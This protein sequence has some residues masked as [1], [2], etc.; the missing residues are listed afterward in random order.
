MARVC[1]VPPRTQRG[2]ALLLVM[3]LIALLAALVGGFAMAARIEHLQ[4]QVLA[5]GLVA[6][7]AARAGVE[8]A[9]VRLADP[10]PRRRWQPDGRDYRWRFGSAQVL[11]RV[12]DEGGKID[13][14]SAQPPL[15]SGLF[16]ALG[17]ERQQAERLAGA[18]V[19]WRDP[20]IL[21]QPSGGGED[22]DYEAAGLPYGAKDAPFDTQAELQQVLGMTPQLYALAAPHLTVFSGRESPDPAFASA[23]VLTAMGLDAQAIVAQR[24]RWDPASGQ[25]PPQIGGGVSLI[26]ATSDTY[27]IWSRARLGDGRQSLL[28]VVVRSGGTGL[29]G[30]AYLPLQW[31]EGTSLR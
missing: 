4:G 13:L 18:V 27:S 20:D 10:E 29:P 31:E 23:Q 15:L 28:R 16:R 22:R 11:V 9:L 30:M 24:Q 19:D 2:A 1:Q 21:T 12:I 8:Y 25:P 3:W 6:Q 14:N 26:G 17:L 5:R 7:Q